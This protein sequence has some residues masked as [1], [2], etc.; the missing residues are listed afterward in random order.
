MKLLLLTF[1]TILIEGAKKKI[2]YPAISSHKR[3]TD[4]KEELYCE[5]CHGV[6]SQSLK[7]LRGS[8]K[9]SDIFLM[10]ES[11]CQVDLYKD[12][13]FPPPFMSDTCDQLI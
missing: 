12:Y 8:A 2:D 4:I 13:R 7:S 5:G 6:L 3:P 10:L 1:L 9:E 11:I